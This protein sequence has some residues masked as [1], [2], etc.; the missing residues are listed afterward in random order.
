MDDLLFVFKLEHLFITFSH[1]VLVLYFF[2]YSH[3]IISLSNNSIQGHMIRIVLN[4]NCHFAC[5]LQ[6]NRL[7]QKNIYPNV[8]SG[9]INDHI[10][11]SFVALNILNEI[12]FIQQ[13]YFLH[14]TY[15]KKALR[16][17]ISLIFSCRV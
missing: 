2:I 6:L 8:P 13:I 10:D 16:L 4:Q 12:L 9:S 17:S 5:I 7:N 11:I 1:L 15:V 14:R 3:P